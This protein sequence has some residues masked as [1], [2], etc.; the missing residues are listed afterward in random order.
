MWL[1]FLFVYTVI[2][3]VP[4]GLV[5]TSFENGLIKVGEWEYTVPKNTELLCVLKR[6][7]MLSFKFSESIHR[8]SM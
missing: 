8:N 3:H 4:Y 6:D 7:G 1:Y 2:T 5:E